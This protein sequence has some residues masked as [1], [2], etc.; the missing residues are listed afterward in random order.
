M[1]KTK[2]VTAYL[3]DDHK[4]INSNEYTRLKYSGKTVYK[5]YVYANGSVIVDEHK[6]GQYRERG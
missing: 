4:Q 5:V 3:D 1:N 6:P 2:I